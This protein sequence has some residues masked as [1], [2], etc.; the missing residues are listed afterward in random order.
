MTGAD[1]P[2]IQPSSTTT[3]Q[4][5]NMKKEPQRTRTSRLVDLEGCGGG[6]VLESRFQAVDSTGEQAAAEDSVTDITAGVDSLHM[7]STSRDAQVIEAKLEKALRKLSDEG[8]DLDVSKLAPHLPLLSGATASQ[9]DQMQAQLAALR[10]ACS[11][12]EPKVTNED[13]Q[14]PM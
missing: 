2:P 9:D 14:P 1:P 8:L 13:L 7:S 3:A 12:T 5:R 10:K 6:L 4:L 11:L